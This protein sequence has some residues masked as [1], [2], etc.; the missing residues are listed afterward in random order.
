MAAVSSA[1]LAAVMHSNNNH[2]NTQHSSITPAPSAEAWNE[3]SFRNLVYQL[4]YNTNNANANTASRHPQHHQVLQQHQPIS[5]IPPQA[6]LSNHTFTAPEFSS[7][8]ITPSCSPSP[9]AYDHDSANDAVL[10]DH[11]DNN[12]DSKKRLKVLQR[13]RA[14]A[15]KCRQKKK[16]LNQEL[17]EKS[18]KLTKKNNE[19]HD[20]VNMLK[21]EVLLLKNQLLMHRKCSCT[22]IQKLIHSAELL[23]LQ[24]FDYKH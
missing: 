1:A 13:N 4:S 9:S 23:P 10:S 20:M 17:E 15:L 8:C 16:R 19:L 22:Q 24:F 12:D 18:V 11:G 2:I 21:E 6:A 14:A 3:A 7:T 5:T